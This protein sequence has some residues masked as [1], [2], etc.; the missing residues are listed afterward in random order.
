MSRIFLSHSSK[1]NFAAVAVGDWLKAEGWED[2]FLDVD[3]KEGIR[4]GERW[5]R[6]L[7]TQ[8]SDCEA[9]LFLVSRNWLASEWCRREHD[10]ARRLN[11]CIFVV[12]IETIAIDDLP[13]FLKETRQ[14]VSLAAGEDHLVFHPR[15][16][17][18]Q[19]EGQITFSAE[20]LARLKNGL[21][22]A[23][24][25]PR[26]FAWPPEV[27]P[28]RAPYR[29]LEPLDGVDAGV[30]FGRDGPIIEALDAL[31]GLREAAAPRLFVILGASGAGKSS[32]LRAGLLPRLQRDDRNFLALPTIRPERTAISGAN[33]FVAALAAAAVKLG[34]GISRA[35]IRELIVGGAAA[36]ARSC[37]NW[38][39]APAR[40][41]RE[42][43]SSP[44]TK[45]KSFSPPKAQPRANACWSCCAISP[46]RTARRSSLF[47]P[48]GPTAMTRWNTQ[49]HLK[50]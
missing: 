13:L 50:A 18:T 10:L 43:W 17:V 7:Y 33:G 25:D 15:M 3:S 39:R 16:P 14:A 41:N 49:D 6:A 34:L 26:F 19:E 31:R 24:L 5:E 36:G 37:K 12:L 2:V 20:G 22:R 38:P 29:G 4:P 42:H 27:D 45:R 46:A 1:D 21:T 28:G 48:S 11:K 8:A 23:G 44:S 47:S 35:Q 30:F 32:F 40:K 9:V